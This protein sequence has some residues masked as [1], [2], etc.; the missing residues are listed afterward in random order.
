M[1]ALVAI[2]SRKFDHFS[3]LNTAYITL[4]PKT[5]GADQVKDFRRISLVHSFATLIIKILANRLAKR[6]NVM[7]SPS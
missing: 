7:V 3:K 5:D 1:A 4:I 6:L 2:W